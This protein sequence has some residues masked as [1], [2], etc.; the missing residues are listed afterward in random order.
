MR[1]IYKY[2][3]PVKDHAKVELPVGAEILHVGEQGGHL[4][5]W[6]VV[7]P[8]VTD[9][10]PRHFRVVGTGH[11]FDWDTWVYQ[12]TVQIGPFVWHLFEEE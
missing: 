5:V 1:R 7:D 6:A 12:G 11:D 4:T 3:I 10:E 8:L 2:R 9:T